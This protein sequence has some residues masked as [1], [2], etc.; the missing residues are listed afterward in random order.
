MSEN[1]HELLWCRC[2]RIN[3]TRAI[4]HCCGY[5]NCYR[6]GCEH[7][8]QYRQCL[9][10][11][12]TKQHEHNERPHDVVLLFHRQRPQMSKRCE[13]KCRRVRRAAPN[14]EP[15]GDIQKATHYIATQHAQ[16]V[17]I[18]QRAIHSGS[19]QQRE[20]CRQQSSSTTH[21]EIA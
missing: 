20:Q 15:I 19:E 8:T 2:K 3:G 14:L 21:P 10:P 12:S 18:K 1:R 11:D 4:N 7:K 9:R 17:A 13:S 16:T 5:S 6:H